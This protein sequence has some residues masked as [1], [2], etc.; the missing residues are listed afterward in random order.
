MYGM[1]LYVWAVMISIF[2]VVVVHLGGRVVVM[3][4]NTLLGL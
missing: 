1:K 3:L 4:V 2:I